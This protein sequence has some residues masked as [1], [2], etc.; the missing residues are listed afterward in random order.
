MKKFLLI[1]MLCPLLMVMSCRDNT[2]TSNETTTTVSADANSME[3]ALEKEIYASNAQMPMQVDYA[4]TLRSV[5]RDGNVVTYEYGIDES[6]FNFDDII[7]RSE[8]FKANLKEQIKLMSSPDSEVYTF[9][10]LLKKTGKDLRYLYKGKNT[11]KTMTIV[12]TNDEL[13]ELIQDF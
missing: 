9:M 8:D 10:S 4:T 6:V 5:T 1:F 2:A 13:K 12:I 3:A 11:G 7:A